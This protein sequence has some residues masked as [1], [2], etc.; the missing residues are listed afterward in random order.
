MPFSVSNSVHF[1]SGRILTWGL[2]PA[3]QGLFLSQIQLR[4]AL[5]LAS[6][7]SLPS[8]GLSGVSHHAQLETMS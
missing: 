4:Q 3:I 1:C 6:H 8:A 2:E 5:N 7:L